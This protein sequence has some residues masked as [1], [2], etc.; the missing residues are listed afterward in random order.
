MGLGPANNEE[1]RGGGG[2]KATGDGREGSNS[3][4]DTLRRGRAG[5]KVRRQHR[6]RIP[7]RDDKE[8]AAEPIRKPKHLS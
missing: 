5:G 1:R 6:H 3:G 2:G 8:V 7:K 4:E